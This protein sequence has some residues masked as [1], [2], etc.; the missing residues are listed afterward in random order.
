MG[1]SM[2]LSMRCVATVCCVFVLTGCS[3]VNFKQLS[4]QGPEFNFVEYFS[5]HTRA[6]GWFA[7][8]FG[9]VKRHFCGDFYGEQKGEVFDLV[10]KLYYSDGIIE[11]RVWSVSIQPNGEFK[12]ESDSLV[13]AAVGEQSGSGLKLHYIMNVMIAEDK[14]WKLKMNDYMFFQPDR[15]LHNSTE[16]KKWGIRI[17]NVSTQYYKHDGSETCLAMQE[18]ASVPIR[19][20]SVVS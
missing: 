2:R 11:D 9:N 19:K 12:A 20:L 16:V 17:G 7:D 6:S 10:E 1:L 4:T 14:F 13:G 3:S 15:S 8:R 18:V 5:G